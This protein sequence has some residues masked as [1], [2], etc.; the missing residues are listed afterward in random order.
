MIEEIDFKRNALSKG[1]DELLSSYGFN[2][3]KMCDEEKALI[4]NL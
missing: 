1:N 3:K 2:P 4:L